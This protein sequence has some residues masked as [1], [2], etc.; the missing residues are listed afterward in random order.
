MSQCEQ[1]GQEIAI[2]EVNADDVR[3]AL[4]KWGKGYKAK[5]STA[6]GSQEV[7]IDNAIIPTVSD[8]AVDIY[9]TVNP[10]RDGKGAVMKTYIDL[11]GI[12]LSSSE[13]PMAFTAIEKEIIDFAREQL[14]AFADENVK[15]EEK[16]LSSLESDLK[17]LQK[18]KANY[19]KDIRNNTDNI[20]KREQEIIQNESDQ[21]IKEQQMVI[22][23]GIVQ[24]TRMKR[25][26]MGTVDEATKKLLDNQVKTEE[27]NLKTF[28]NQLKS[29][30]SNMAAAVK[31]IEK[32]RSTIAQREQ[33]IIKNQEDQV[34]KEQQIE[35]QKKI[36]EMVRQKRAEIR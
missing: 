7:F 28:E 18:D 29:L 27:K 31:D 6:K 36:L 19:E 3:K 23:Q 12:F 35:L 21:K 5:F 4:N 26:S 15:A 2:P 14:I 25:S 11:G 20:A 30:R 8:N 33:E 32:S 16:H 17:S 1:T 34:T 13:H 22:Q 9:V 10:G 24:E